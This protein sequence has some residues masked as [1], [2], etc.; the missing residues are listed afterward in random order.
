[1][2]LRNSRDVRQNELVVLEIKDDIIQTN[3]KHQ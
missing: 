2:K 3:K 1:M